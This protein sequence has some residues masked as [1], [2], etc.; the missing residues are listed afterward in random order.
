MSHKYPLIAAAV[1]AAFASQIAGAA[2]P[3]PAQAA[4]PAASLV[5]SGSSAAAPAVANFI[6]NTLCGSS[7]NTLQVSSVGGTK[8]FLAYACFLPAAITDPTGPG[9][10]I[11][12]GSLVTIYYRTEGGSV[13]GAIPVAANHAIKRLNLADT[14]CGGTGLTA[15][16]TITG[17]TS[18]AG[19]GDTW[20]GAVVA[21]QTQLGVTDV[22]PGQLTG[23]DSPLPPNGNYATSA[24][25]NPNQKQMAALST[26]PLLQQVF[27]LVVNTSGQSFSAVNLSRESAANILQGNYTDWSSVPDAS[28]GNSVSSGSSHITRVDREAG[29][30]TRTSANIYFLGYQ[31]SSTT[32][33]TNNAGETLNFSTGDELT[34]A[35]STAGSIA[36][37]SIDNIKAPSNGT[38]Y[39]NLVLASI[40]NVAASNL[41]AAAGSYDYW[42]EAT[43]VPNAPA[44][45]GSSLTLSDFLIANLPDLT[46]A[47]QL[48]DINVIPGASSNNIPTVAATGGPANN[49]KTGTLEVFV[50]PF[51]R[52]GNSCNVPAETN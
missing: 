25:G 23:G 17:T 40:N 16:C 13:V 5:M 12:S 51:T 24:F 20:A 30:G 41:A 29:S 34:L 31:C 50:N 7:A 22:E 43:L 6:E 14:S 10:S 15:T 26:F 2:V 52:G 32:N 39:P 3:T 1:A 9:P 36:Y 45:S 38:K 42:F 27:G 18:I 46:S 33:I 37:A 35:N 4:A 21:A 8:N 11:S 19:T 44:T 48:P 47:P 49:G 28:T